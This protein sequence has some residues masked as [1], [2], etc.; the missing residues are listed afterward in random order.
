[1]GLLKPPYPGKLV[2]GFIYRESAIKDRALAALKKRYGAIDYCSQELDFIYTDYYYP[3]F[4]KPL[5]RLFI[6]FEPLLSEDGL[7]AI[8][9]YTNALEKRF[10]KGG[11]RLINIDP[12]MLNLGKLILATTK[13]NV[14]R[15]Y[16]GKGIFAEVT[17]YFRRDSFTPWQ[18]TYPDYQSKEYISIFNAIRALYQQQVQCIRD[19]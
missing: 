10:S 15:I 18:W 19:T 7:L 6:S 12:G 5:K 14:H 8:K 2:A 17:L 11:K 9:R 16:L 1:M 3:E 13:D 4:G